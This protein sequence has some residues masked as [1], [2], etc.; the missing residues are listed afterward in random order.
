MGA[1]GC[2]YL[3]KMTFNVENRFSKQ[4]ESISK[5]ISTHVYTWHTYTYNQENN[6]VAVSRITVSTKIFLLFA[7]KNFYYLWLD[8]MSCLDLKSHQNNFFFC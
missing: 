7:S 4:C 3:I 2:M 8:C 6:F 1:I 5:A